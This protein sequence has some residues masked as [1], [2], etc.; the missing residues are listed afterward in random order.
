M[1][2]II[3]DV[4]EQLAAT[5][6]RKEKEAILES[7]KGN[8]LLM[9][10]LRTAYD[11]H[12]NFWIKKI[13]E[14]TNE[15]VIRISLNH[16]LDKLDA[17]INRNVTGNAAID[18]LA[19]I[20]GE[21]NK[22][23]RDVLARIIQRDLRCGVSE[24][25]INKIWKGL[26]PTYP[27]L[28]ASSDD[29]KARAKVKFPA[30]AQEKCDGM[31][32]NAIV[33]FG[34]VTY[35]SRNGKTV[36]CN[37][38]ALDSQV[39]TIASYFD[40]SIVLDGELLVW[41][42]A[43]DAPMSR[44]VGNGI[45]N[46]AIKGTVSEKEKNLFVICVWDAIPVNDFEK[47]SC[48]VSYEKRKQS[49]ENAFELASFAVS[50]VFPVRSWKIDSWEKAKQIYSDVVAQGKEGLIIK[51][52]KGIWEDKRSPDLVK[53]KEEVENAFVVVD[54]VE[55]TGKYKGKL[56]ALVCESGGNNPVRVSVGSGFSDEERETITAKNIIGKIISVVYNEIITAEDGTRSLFLPR[57]DQIREDKSFPDSL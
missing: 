46:K 37:S 19:Q 25:T 26:V 52:T 57:F 43:T 48:S 21:L 40:G 30:I 6:S 45:C 13:P 24:A 53:M 9:R 54:W 7:Q 29:P 50:R 17:I 18:R 44:K 32:I 55:G 42:N 16:A 39:L 10:V 51:N 47:G 41:D 3:Y 8:T 28:L 33:Q 56:G 23:D 2:D 35:K 22:K 31:R 14:V 11:P 36:D 27:C 38:D 12:L 20:L 49:Y 5:N 4:L 15:P 34:A 1:N